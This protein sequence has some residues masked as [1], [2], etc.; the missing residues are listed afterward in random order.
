[1]FW[2][3]ACDRRG[4]LGPAP[5]IILFPAFTP[6]RATTRME[7]GKW[8]IVSSYSSATASDLHGVP[9]RRP[10]TYSQRTAE[11]LARGARESKAVLRGSRRVRRVWN[12]RGANDERF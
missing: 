8:G 4:G 10:L 3:L 2:L 1:M 11:I 5:A 7:I 9:F 6:G 12:L